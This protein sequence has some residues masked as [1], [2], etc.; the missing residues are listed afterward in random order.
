GDGDES[1]EVHQL[2]DLALV[3]PARLDVG[4]DLLDA[5][6]GGATGSGVDGRDG[7]RAVVLDV[8]LGAG[9]LGDRLDD[10]TALADHFADLV[11]VDLDGDQARRELGELRTRRG[12]RGL[13]FLEDVQ[14]ALLRLRQRDL[15]D[16]FGDALD[17]DV[18][19][20]RRNTLLGA[21]DLEVHVA[22]VVLI[23]E[24]VGQH[25]VVVAF[26]HQAHGDARDRRLDRH[27]RVHQ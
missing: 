18:H 3:D 21:G 7:D 15:H 10:R 6:L 9:F 22:Q 20:Q 16:L 19:L 11:G 1:T 2:D 12:Q 24:D 27:A 25:D 5:L 26:F 14:A 8:D 17:L 13:H 23:T 4:G